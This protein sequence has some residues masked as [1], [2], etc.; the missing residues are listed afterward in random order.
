L[1]T[2]LGFEI[3]RDDIS[4]N[5]RIVCNGVCTIGLF[6]KNVLRFKPGWKSQAEAL[7]SFMGVRGIQR[8]LKAVSVPTGTE[9]DS[10][11]ESSRLS[12]TEPHGNFIILDQHVPLPS[13]LLPSNS[14]S[15]LIASGHKVS[16]SAC[17]H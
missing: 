9:A 11:E 6:D 15:S 13:C 5:Q 12:M 14:G 16:F 17:T 3:V 7:E 8:W 2:T 1:F 10:T 4:Q